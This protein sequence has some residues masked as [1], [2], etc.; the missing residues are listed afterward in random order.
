MTDAA[1]QHQSLRKMIARDLRAR[2]LKRDIHPGEKLVV[3]D[4]AS[5][6]R[7]SS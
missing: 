5:Q 6:Y 4:I 1:L 3:T 2:I 7:V